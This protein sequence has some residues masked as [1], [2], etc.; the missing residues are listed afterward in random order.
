TLKL[1]VGVSGMVGLQRPAVAR[2]PARVLRQYRLMYDAYF[3]DRP[4]VPPGQLHEVRFEELER[5]P[6]R[7]IERTY[8]TLNLP[9]FG[10][11]RRVGA[12]SLASR[13]GYEK[14]ESPPLEEAQQRRVA[15]EWRR[16]FE[17]WGYAT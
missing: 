11:T 1:F 16:N 7:E 15:E 5:D 17:E 12:D 13:M 3:A 2:I 6:L 8:A 10:E 14:G 4:L 9:G